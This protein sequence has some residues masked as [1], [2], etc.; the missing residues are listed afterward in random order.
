MDGNVHTGAPPPWLQT[1]DIKVNSAPAVP[2]SRAQERRLKKSR[3]P[4]RV[5]AAWADKRRAEMEREKAGVCLKRGLESD[6]GWLPNFGGVW[7]SGSRRETRK[8]FESEK[9]LCKGLEASKPEKPK[10][11]Q[12]YISKRQRM[13]ESASKQ[14]SS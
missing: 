13:E 1:G 4:K 10:V 7:Q 6:K 12:P 5:G 9:W 11:V 3:N 2:L 8:E 14:S